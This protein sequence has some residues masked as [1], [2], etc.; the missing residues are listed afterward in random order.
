MSPIVSYKDFWPVYLAQHSRPGTRGLHYA[1]TLCGLVLLVGALVVWDWRLLVL[2]PLAGY[3]PAWLGHLL[4][5]R[6]RPASFRHPIWSLVSDLRMLGLWLT[7][8]LAAE[9][10]HH[11]IAPQ[12]VQADRR[13]GTSSRR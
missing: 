8:R 3:G 2:A 11:E 6:N 7:G 12:A 13:H 4:V 5:E 10:A 9:L 1:G